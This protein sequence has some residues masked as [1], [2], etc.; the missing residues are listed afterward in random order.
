M[1]FERCPNC[2]PTKKY[3]ICLLHNFCYPEKKLFKIYKNQAVRNHPKT[4][5]EMYPICKPTKPG[6]LNR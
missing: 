2:I 3:P 6:S 5:H 1:T 4:G